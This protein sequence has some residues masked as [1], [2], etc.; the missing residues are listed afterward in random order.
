VVPAADGEA[1]LFS[2]QHLLQAAAEIGQTWTYLT[3]SIASWC[4]SAD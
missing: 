3:C 1:R 2:R 4:G